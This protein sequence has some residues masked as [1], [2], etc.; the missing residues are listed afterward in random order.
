MYLTYRLETTSF[1]RI[2]HIGKQK[3]KTAVASFRQEATHKLAHCHDVISNSG[4][5][6]AHLNFLVNFYFYHLTIWYK[7]MTAKVFFK[8]L[9]SSLNPPCIPIQ[10]QGIYQKEGETKADLEDKF[11]PES[12]DG[13]QEMTLV[14]HKRI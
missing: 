4:I 10:L 3:K 11:K 12:Q 9:V 7:F 8:S 6:Y 13:I 1:R 2:F 14:I 5:P